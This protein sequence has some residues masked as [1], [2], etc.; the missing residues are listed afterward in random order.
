VPRATRRFAAGALAFL[1]TAV[2]TASIGCH[3]DS[4]GCCM[5]CPSGQCAC[6]D[7]CISCADK[8]LQGKGCACTSSIPSAVPPAETR[9][10][11][12]PPAPMSEP[13]DANQ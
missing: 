11:E 8:C 5:I 3:D 9:A 7:S 1:L 6:G 13:P 12:T 10:T 4:T 2:F